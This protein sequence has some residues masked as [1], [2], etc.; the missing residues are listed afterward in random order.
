MIFCYNLTF[1]DI[2]AQSVQILFEIILMRT[3]P[4]PRD[5]NSPFDWFSVSL[6]LPLA[7]RKAVISTGQVQ[8]C[9]R[10]GISEILSNWNGSKEAQATSLLKA[11]SKQ[12]KFGYEAAKLTSLL[13][14]LLEMK[15]LFNILGRYLVRLHMGMV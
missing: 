1:I 2:E 7:I 3:K 11:Q 14:H 4:H 13:R 8:G 9:D 12:A 15:H 10:N 6:N 5:V